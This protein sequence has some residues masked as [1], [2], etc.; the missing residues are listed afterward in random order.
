VALQYIA[1]S[2]QIYQDIKAANIVLFDDG[3]ARLT[4]FDGGRTAGHFEWH[5]DCFGLG[6]LLE[7][8]DCKGEDLDEL[9]RLAKT[10]KMR[11]DDFEGLLKAVLKNVD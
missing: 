2:S 1:A 10:T 9:I 8:L 3:E 7:D 5:M 11:L 4:D 6:V